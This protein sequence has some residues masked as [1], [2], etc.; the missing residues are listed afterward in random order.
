MSSVELLDQVSSSSFVC[1]L[2]AAVMPHGMGRDL[3]LHN[4]P[5]EPSCFAEEKA[6]SQ[7]RIV[8]AAFQQATSRLPISDVDNASLSGTVWGLH[9]IRLKI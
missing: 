5:H 6:F 7:M 2:P 8:P 3:Q 9:Y 4:A 1:L